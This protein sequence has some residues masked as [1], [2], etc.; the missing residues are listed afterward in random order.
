[1]NKYNKYNSSIKQYIISSIQDRDCAI[2][3]SLLR[4]KRLSHSSLGSS[5]SSFK[6][7]Y[8]KKCTKPKTLIIFPSNKDI[9]Y[10]PSNYLHKHPQTILA[11]FREE[12]NL[13]KTLYLSD[14]YTSVAL[15]N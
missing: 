4:L 3:Q 12:N 14:T 8:I 5:S 7:S 10:S 1:M 9:K 11:V 15:I 2:Y 13:M 6:S